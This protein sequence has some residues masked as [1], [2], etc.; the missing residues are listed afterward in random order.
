MSGSVK[1]ENCAGFVRGLVKTA[2]TP[3]VVKSG[4][5]N[6][7]GSVNAGR[8]GCVGRGSLKKLQDLTTVW[9]AFCA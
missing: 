1:V 3:S 9:T 4:S 5:A 7:A 6:G 2:N 8:G